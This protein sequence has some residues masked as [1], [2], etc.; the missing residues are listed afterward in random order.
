M[1]GVLPT[2]PLSTPLHT[3]KGWLVASAA[4]QLWCT[5]AANATAQTKLISVPAHFT[6]PHAIVD[7]SPDLNR[8]RDGVTIGAFIQGGGVLLYFCADA[9]QGADDDAET[10]FMNR[11]GAVMLDLELIANQGGVPPVLNGYSLANGP[12]RI[13]ATERDKHGGNMDQLEVMFAL[14]LTVWP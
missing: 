14:D 6:R 5:G 8:T 4:W 7:F 11:V 9:G 12:A 10:E 1:P 2:G 3:V 13:S